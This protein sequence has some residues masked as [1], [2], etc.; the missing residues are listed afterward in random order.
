MEVLAY[1]ACPFSTGGRDGRPLNE[2]ERRAAQAWVRAGQARDGDKD[3][4][5]KGGG[6]R[7][8]AWLV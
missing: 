6:A 4:E 8:G 5:E 3:A 1:L 7:E 2:R